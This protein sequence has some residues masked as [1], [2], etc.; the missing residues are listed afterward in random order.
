MTEPTDR[1]ELLDDPSMRVLAAKDANELRAAYDDWSA[2]YNDAVAE[3]KWDTD[4]VPR[5]AELTA[6]LVDK[7]GRILDAPCGTGLVGLA[8]ARHGF[9]RIEGVDLSPKMLER[10]DETGVYQ[11]TRIL[12]FEDPLPID[13]DIYDAVTSAAMYMP[14]HC[15]ADPSLREF[16]RVT[17]PGGHVIFTHTVYDEV[18]HPGLNELSAELEHEGMW[19]LV[20][21]DLIQEIP[22]Y[23]EGESGEQVEHMWACHLLAYQRL[24]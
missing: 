12:N 13:S 15:P 5:V 17:R 9:G 24:G 14:G 23:E 4:G 2:T 1:A 10:A 20:S 16:A 3:V 7:D 21:N 19:R 8:L 11:S 22:L 18:P 6:K